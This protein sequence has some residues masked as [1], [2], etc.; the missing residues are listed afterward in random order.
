MDAERI[1]CLGHSLGGHSAMF[2]AA[3]DQR[4]KAI[5]SSCGFTRFHK[6]DLPS[7]TGP[8]YMPRIASVY[9]NDADRLPLDFTEIV[10]SFAPRAFLA[11]AAQRDDDFDVSGVR[12]AIAS[13]A[14]AYKLH[15]R[16]ER[17]Q[18][19]Y[20]DSGHAFPKHSRQAAY[21]FLDGMLRKPPKP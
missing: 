19:L 14:T 20:P 3:F 2:T 21:E 13:A 11:C 15:D 8:R 9:G 4:L 17:L 16:P 7:W 10:A 1:G 5:V 6:D 18:A 12:D